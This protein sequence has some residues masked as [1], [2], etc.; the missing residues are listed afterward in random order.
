MRSVMVRSALV[1]S[2]VVRRIM[3]RMVRRMQRGDA[4]IVGKSDILC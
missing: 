3:R 2:A 4:W 1:R